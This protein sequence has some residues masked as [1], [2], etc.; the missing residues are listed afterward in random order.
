MPH[1]ESESVRPAALGAMSG[2]S[3]G[4]SV[5][6]GIGGAHAQA[7]LPSLH[8]GH[9]NPT[10]SLTGIG[11]SAPR[12]PVAGAQSALGGGLMLQASAMAERPPVLASEPSPLLSQQQ[13]SLGG[14]LPQ[15]GPAVSGPS[16]PY[17]QLKVEDALAYL[18]KVKAKFDKQPHIYNQVSMLESL[19][20]GPGSPCR[21]V[22]FPCPPST[23]HVDLPPLPG[24]TDA[25]S[26][27]PAHRRA[28][29]IRREKLLRHSR[30]QHRQ[31]W[32]AS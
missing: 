16:Q 10:Q 9:L 6:S 3:A 4:V 29:H 18:D 25:H 32:K 20:L 30:Q 2:C 7:A 12:L 23:I 5:P 27:M 31:H 17:R 15:G 13:V 8:M 19:M 1:S 28:P 24:L 11:A 14:N 21:G 22:V 26:R